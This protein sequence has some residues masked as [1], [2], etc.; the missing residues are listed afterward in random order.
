MIREETN[1][2]FEDGIEKSVTRDHRFSSVGKPR[3]ANR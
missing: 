3:D 1:P 2:L